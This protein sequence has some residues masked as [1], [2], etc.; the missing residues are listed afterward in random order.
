MKKILSVLLVCLMLVPVFALAE[1]APIDLY[2]FQ[3]KVDTIDQMQNLADQFAAQYDKANI[4]IHVET[5]GGTGDYQGTLATKFA[6]NDIPDLFAISGTSTLR[7][8]QSA[9]L[10]LTGE[11][12]IDNTVG[13]LLNSC[14]LDGEIYGQPL[15]IEAYSFFYNKDLFEQ[16][17]ITEAPTTFSELVAV[18]EKLDAA[19]IRPFVSAF[20]EDWIIAQ[21]YF[22]GAFLAK[23]GGTIDADLGVTD[24]LANHKKE[25]EEMAQLLQLC[26]KYGGG[27]GALATDYNTSLS[28]FAAG[29][30]AILASQGT[31][32]QP[33]LDGI[34][35]D[36][37]IGMF[38]FLT[39][40]D[41][42]ADV[43]P[44]GNQGFWVIHNAGEHVDI[45]KDFL[46]YMA[47]DEAAINSIINDFQFIPAFTGVD[48]DLSTLG[49]IYAV[50]QPYITEGKTEE[51]L[52]GN[53]PDGFASLLAPYFQ[54]L[55]VGMMDVDTFIAEVDAAITSAR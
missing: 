51:W 42:N 43:V 28:E 46:T 49:S 27:E 30:G 11:P 15:C 41:A 33:T 44:V 50:L 13:G 45:M 39:N 22:N 40:D 53:L 1:D 21:H 24:T 17:G 3:F 16:A 26:V 9:E 20:A 34:N 4:K 6:A 19:G 36:L 32:T 48:Y 55:A 23:V 35:P 7:T 2:V 12:W 38:G 8:Y 31:W 10:P 37:N 29:E 18:C 14:T 54:Q 47:T 52:W 5:V 25:V